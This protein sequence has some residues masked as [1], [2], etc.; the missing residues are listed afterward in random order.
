MSSLQHM[1]A[2]KIPTK[3][4]TSIKA[5]VF[6]SENNI[7]KKGV[8]DTPFFNSISSYSS[9]LFVIKFPIDH[10]LGVRAG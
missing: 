5:L 6:S 2:G 9:T 8:F 1:R 4:N 3:A 10:I 7:R